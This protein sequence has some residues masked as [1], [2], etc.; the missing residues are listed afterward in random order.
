MVDFAAFV[1]SFSVIYTIKV[2]VKDDTDPLG[3]RLQLKGT[4]FTDG[5]QTHAVRNLSPSCTFNHRLK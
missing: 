3:V 4:L 1:P 5:E 2:M